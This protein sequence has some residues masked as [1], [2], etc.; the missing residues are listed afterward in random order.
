MMLTENNNA[1]AYAAN[2]TNKILGITMKGERAS[3]SDVTNG[4]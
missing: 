4:R 1:V 2:N 3:V